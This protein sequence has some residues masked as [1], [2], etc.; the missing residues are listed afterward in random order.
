MHGGTVG[1]EREVGRGNLGVNE[2]CRWARF[3]D[4][5]TKWEGVWGIEIACKYD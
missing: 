1:G 5:D 3:G 4:S 2:K